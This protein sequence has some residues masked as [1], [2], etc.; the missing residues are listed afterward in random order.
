MSCCSLNGN[1]PPLCQPQG[2]PVAGPFPI[3]APA[4]PSDGTFALMSISPDWAPNSLWSWLSLWLPPLVSFILANKS[5][6]RTEMIWYGFWF[7]TTRKLGHGLPRFSGCP[8]S[9]SLNSVR[10]ERKLSTILWSLYPIRL[11]LAWPTTGDLAY[12][13]EIRME[14]SSSLNI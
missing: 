12:P 3:H 4:I 6:M 13:E 14:F 10:V 7:L 8:Q 11:V 5:S 2:V 1:R 9:L